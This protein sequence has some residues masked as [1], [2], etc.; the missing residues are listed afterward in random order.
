MAAVARIVEAFYRGGI[1]MDSLYLKLPCSWRVKLPSS[2]ALGLLLALLSHCSGGA[3][4]G[5]SGSGPGTAPALVFQIQ[6]TT[7]SAECAI[8]PAVQI[9]IE[10]AAGHL[11]TTATNVVTIALGTHPAGGTLFG[12]TT[13]AAVNGV[14]SFRTLT[15]DKAG[16]GYTL[17]ASA[18]GLTGATSAAFAVTPFVVDIDETSGLISFPNKYSGWTVGGF[19]GTNYVALPAGWTV[20]GFAGT[21]YVAVPPDWTVGGFAG[22]N[23]VVYPGPQVTTI[24]LKFNDA[25]FL[26]LFKVLQGSGTYTDVALADIIMAVWVN[27][28][29]QRTPLTRP[30]GEW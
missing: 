9:A 1:T 7:V 2:I 8:T 18:A 15:I 30:A 16:S 11:V 19:A 12:T 28:E 14:A 20:G 25:G 24:Q 22:T 26:A 21:N 3:A 23:Y 5:P 6:P 27:D 10:D 29:S 13:V 4:T 17:V